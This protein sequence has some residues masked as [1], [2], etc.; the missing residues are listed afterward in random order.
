MADATFT[1]VDLSRL[2]APDV[3]E[4][5]NFETIL[6]DAVAQMQARTPDFEARESDPATKLLQVTAYLAQ[7]LR[8][9]VNDAARAVMPAYATGADLDNIAA[10]FGIARLTL[11]PANTALGIPAVMESD[12]DFR[13]RMVL[14]PEGYSVA[15]PE[16]AYIFHALSADADVLD[17]SATSPSPGEVIV[18]V[19]SRQGDGTASPALLATVATFV[20]DETRRPLTDFVSVQS[21]QIVPY[22]VQATL[23][24]Y[25]GP[26]GS[27]VVEAARQQLE[28]YVAASHRL[29]RDITRSGLFAALHAEGVQNVVLSAP[30]AD[31]IVTRTQAPHCAGISLTYAGTGE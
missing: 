20:S 11:T 2:P 23:T 5:L 21:A 12:A 22:A 14:A 15:G 26:D 27:V 17:A 29:G 25:S 1:A 8:Q 19:L 28:D 31:L 9:R 13:R 3:I 18:S 16:G 7:L 6:A 10:L 30:V 24:T 4:K